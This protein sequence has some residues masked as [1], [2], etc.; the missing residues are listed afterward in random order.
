[1][2]AEGLFQTRQTFNEG[3]DSGP[4]WSPFGDKIVFHRFANDYDIYVMNVDGSDETNLTMHP[5][6]DQTPDWSPAH[7]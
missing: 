5:A 6:S 7:R 3:V 4:S 2:R 1:M